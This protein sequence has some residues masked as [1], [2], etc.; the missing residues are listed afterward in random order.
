MRN[1][2]NYPYY[3]VNFLQLGDADSIILA[4]KENAISPLRIALIDAGNV[5]DAE[6]IQNEI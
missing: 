2:T 5:G 1:I 4:Y 3:E 6:T